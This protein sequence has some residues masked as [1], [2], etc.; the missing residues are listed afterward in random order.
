M[1][2]VR[3]RL[4]I[5]AGVICGALF[6]AGAAWAAASTQIT[7]AQGLDNPHG[8]ILSTSKSC[9]GNRKVIAFQQLGATQNPA[10]DTKMD[11]TSSARQGNIGIWDMGNPGF[12][13]HKKY[14]V[15]ATAKTG[16]KAAFS[17]TQTFT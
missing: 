10:G 3:A 2:M 6:I 8:K 9:L 14:Y 12:P 4:S 1:M 17:K 16:C 5:A 15:E 13:K 7:L 11:T